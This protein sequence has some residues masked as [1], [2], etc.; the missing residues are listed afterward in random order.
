MSQIKF[1]TDGWRAIIARDFT[2]E[3]CRI[4]TQGIASYLNSKNLA[5]KGIVI[6]YDN[7]FMSEDFAKECARVM[8]GNGIKVYLLAK[9]TPTPVTAFAIRETEASGAIMITAS[10]NPAEYNG[11]K[12][13]PEY[14]GPALPDVTDAIEDQV[15]KVIEQNKIYEL[16]LTEAVKLELFK[17]IDVDT[18][19]TNQL[20]GLIKPEFFKDKP[21]KVIVDPMY[22]VGIGYL[23]NILTELGCEVR[24]INNFRDPLFGGAMPEPTDEWLGNLK[25]LVMSS[26]ADIGL[27][28][29]GDADRFGIIDKNGVFVNANRFMYI[30]LDHLLKTRA[31][32]GPVARSIATTHMLDRIAK[33]N[34]LAVIE[35][36]VG[37]KYI[38]ECLREKGCILGGE[39]SG[40]LSIFG[41]I[42]EK[43]GVLACL[44]AVELLAYSGKTLAE[45]GQAIEDEYGVLV[46]ERLDIKVEAATKN[47]IIAKL[48]DYTPRTIADVP[49]SS[50]STIE[51]NKIIL[52][53]GSWVLIRSSG[54]EPLFRI[55][56][57]TD[58]EEKL[59][60]I[61]DE[62]ML[63]IGIKNL[64]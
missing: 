64:G 20:L 10:H 33:K 1:G 31:Y 32:K 60:K 27:A 23:E 44:L 58:N 2:F 28:L 22:G 41:H 53:D 50:Y 54:T 30:L 4:V 7:R 17:E 24:T 13:I 51:G 59:K 26:D 29:D 19:Y 11:I 52:E 39:E 45:L 42:P 43:D 15:S 55:Y 46:S 48:N 37:F 14:A 62:V 56:V 63:A 16:S 61:Q 3:N 34:G 5:R 36:P 47:K 49:V 57:E 21:L 25:R 8:V 12:F 35:T 40:G 6:G 18:Q 38:G 9:A